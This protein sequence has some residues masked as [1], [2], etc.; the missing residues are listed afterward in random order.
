MSDFPFPNTDSPGRT[1][2][3]VDDQVAVADSLISELVKDVV[4]SDIACCTKLLVEA[5]AAKR[6]AEAAQRGGRWDVSRGLQTWFYLVGLRLPLDV[7]SC[8]ALI[9]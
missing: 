5:I 3:P 9:G 4:L 1:A 6:G 8:N 7:G 2:V